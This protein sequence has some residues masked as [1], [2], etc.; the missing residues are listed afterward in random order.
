MR[1]MISETPGGPE[2][3]KLMDLPSKPVGKGE[4]RIDVRAGAS[5]EEALSSR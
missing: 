3:L 5:R 1:A 2:S 4:V